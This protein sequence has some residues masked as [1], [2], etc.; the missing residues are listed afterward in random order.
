[1]YNHLLFDDGRSRDL[2]DYEDLET[3]CEFWDECDEWENSWDE[4]DEGENSW[5]GFCMIFP[6]Y[7]VEGAETLREVINC[8]RTR[9]DELEEMENEGWRL[10]QPMGEHSGLLVYEPDEID[11][12]A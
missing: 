5:D 9:A 4:D 8:L 11:C 7:V 12:D 6:A 1:M 10:T 2:G 3:P